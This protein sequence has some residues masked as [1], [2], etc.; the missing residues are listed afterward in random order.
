MMLLPVVLVLAQN[1]HKGSDLNKAFNDHKGA[2]SCPPRRASARSSRRS[3]R[4]EHEFALGGAD[5]DANAT[6]PPSAFDMS[7]SQLQFPAG[8]KNDGIKAI[9]TYDYAP[10]AHFLNLPQRTA[11]PVVPPLPRSA[12][13]NEAAWAAAAAAR[14]PQAAA[15]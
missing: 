14:A 1:D 10:H 8:S 9:V 11:P 7:L 5:A 6:L 3:S 2:S 4:A 13:Q 12:A 15:A